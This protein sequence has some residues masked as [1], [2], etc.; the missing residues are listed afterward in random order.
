MVFIEEWQWRRTQKSLVK[1]FLYSIWA[2]LL[3]LGLSM[4]IGVSTIVPLYMI[5]KDPNNLF[6]IKRELFGAL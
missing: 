4:A 3:F 5:R 2:M 6:G 1:R